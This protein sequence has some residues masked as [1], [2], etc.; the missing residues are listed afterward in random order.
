MIWRGE[1]GNT[2]NL[3]SPDLQKK[4]G[5]RI[6]VYFESLSD[7]NDA[8]HRESRLKKYKRVNLI[9][10]DNPEWRDLAFTWNG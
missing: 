6:L 3:L 1:H 7:I 4:H 10:R 2:G 9:E 8:I 5:V